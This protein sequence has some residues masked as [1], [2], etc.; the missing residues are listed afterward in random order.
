[1][2]NVVASEDMGSLTFGAPKFLRHLMDPSSRN[3]TVMEFDVSKCALDSLTHALAPEYFMYGKVNDKIDV[4]AFGVVLLELLSGRKPISNEYPEGEESLVMWAKPILNS[5]S[6]SK[7][8]LL[9]LKIDSNHEHVEEWFVVR[10]VS[11]R[12][13]RHRCILG[14][15]FE[16][17]L[18][19]YG[20]VVE[21]SGWII[22]ALEKSD[23]VLVH[24]DSNY[25]S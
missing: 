12:L 19:N 9:E 24:Y 6:T 8:S 7:P 5:G 20:T 11:S 16:W 4:Y 15:P 3:T 21:V 18:W 17:R 10:G 1:M 2:I 23:G 22:Q 14:L 13:L 25:T